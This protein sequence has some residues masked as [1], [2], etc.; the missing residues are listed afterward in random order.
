MNATTST[1]HIPFSEM[2]KSEHKANS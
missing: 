2:H 1:S